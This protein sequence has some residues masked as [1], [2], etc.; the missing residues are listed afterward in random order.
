MTFLANIKMSSAITVSNSVTAVTRW[1]FSLQS[2]LPPKK[3]H[4]AFDWQVCPN[5]N[6]NRIRKRL[7]FWTEYSVRRASADYFFITVESDLKIFTLRFWPNA[8]QFQLWFKSALVTHGSRW[9]SK[10]QAPSQIL[11]A[12]L[13]S[14]S[15]S[16]PV[17]WHVHSS[18][19]G[20]WNCP[21]F[22]SPPRGVCPTSTCTV[23]FIFQAT[24]E[25][26][27]VFYS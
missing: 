26:I 27:L 2:K 17:V 19:E 18:P 8:V 14:Q 15:I 6:A 13:A 22:T 24:F 25:E 7:Y 16:V 9:E 4:K 23:G 12:I 21:D 1:C 20:T 10:I 5:S 3:T 11:K